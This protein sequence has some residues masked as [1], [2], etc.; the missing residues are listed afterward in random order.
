MYAPQSGWKCSTALKIHNG[1]IW[2]FYAGLQHHVRFTQHTL[3]NHAY[4]LIQFVKGFIGDAVIAHILTVNSW[5]RGGL[6]NDPE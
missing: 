3:M 5:C 1:I 4:F 2:N 6:I